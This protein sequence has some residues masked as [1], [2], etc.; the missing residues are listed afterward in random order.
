M[1]RCRGVNLQL[2]SVFVAAGNMFHPTL[3][4]MENCFY[5]PGKTHFV[6][7]MPATVVVYNVEQHICQQDAGV[8]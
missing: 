8:L 5:I 6:C 2:V 3:S 1:K 4:I 7:S